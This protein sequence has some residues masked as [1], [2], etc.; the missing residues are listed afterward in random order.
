M[1]ADHLDGVQEG[2]GVGI[3]AGL[4]TGLDHQPAQ[5]EVDQQQA[6][7]F[8]FDQVDPAWRSI[9]CWPPVIISLLRR[10]Q[11]TPAQPVPCAISPPIGGT[12]PVA[13]GWRICPGKA[14]PSNCTCGSAVSAV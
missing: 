6:V 2:Q 10:I 7:E 3:A 13:G 14:A 1:T 9:V 8:L 12:A 5:G 11:R 4:L